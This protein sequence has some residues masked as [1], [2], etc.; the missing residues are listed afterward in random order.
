M[1]QNGSYYLPNI[2]VVPFQETEKR[3]DI[4]SRW[5]EGTALVTDLRMG[6]KFWPVWQTTVDQQKDGKRN[7]IDS[8]QQGHWPRMEAGDDTA[9]KQPVKADRGR[10]QRI[11]GRAT[12]IASLNVLDRTY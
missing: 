9:Y 4:F 10:I 2:R 3:N 11:H 6:G 7:G 1:K 5:S 12:A 8:I